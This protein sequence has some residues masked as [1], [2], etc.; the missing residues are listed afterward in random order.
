LARA[1]ESRASKIARVIRLLDRVRVPIVVFTEYRDTLEAIDAALR[2]R[3]AV[4]TLHGGL[5]A[6]QRQ[7]RVDRL[8]GGD[9]EVLIA[10]DTGGEGLN[11]HQRCRGGDDGAAVNPQRL[12]QRVG[13]VDRIGRGGACTRFTSFMRARSD[14]V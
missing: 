13:R 9:V 3:F 2:D 10:T 7:R 8:T 11:L 1:A 5:I 12:E 6:T 4:A 14:E